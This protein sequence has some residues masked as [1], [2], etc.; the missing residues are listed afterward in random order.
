MSEREPEVNPV[1]VTIGFAA[2]D[3]G[4]GVAFAM[5]DD[6]TQPTTFRVAFSLRLRRALRGR[7][8]AYAAAN[9]VTEA[10]L[11]RGVRSMV[12]RLG[13]ERLVTDLKER[14]ALPTPLSVPYV[15]LRCRLNRFAEARVQAPAGAVGRDLTGRA[16]AE[17]SLDIAA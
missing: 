14:A 13:D 12:L 3:D 2:G 5:L 17:V 10:L 15:A 8:V 6:G 9:A 11:E 7:D 1:M 4:K 16:L